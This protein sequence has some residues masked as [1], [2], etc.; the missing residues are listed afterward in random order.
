MNQT[1][2]GLI[3]H[4]LHPGIAAE[5]SPAAIEA[6]VVEDVPVAVEGQ[7]AVAVAG[8][9][10][11]VGAAVT[12]VAVADRAV[13]AVGTKDRRNQSEL[14]K[15][16]KAVINHGLCFVESLSQTAEVKLRLLGG[17]E[18]RC[19]AVLANARVAWRYA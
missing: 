10:A 18:F 3:P 16:S 15:Q 2:T 7:V 14:S 17:S 19:V 12:V 1:S 5:I 6:P 8:V 11:M 13:A 9:V 4:L